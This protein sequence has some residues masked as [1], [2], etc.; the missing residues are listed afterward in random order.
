MRT[1]TLILTCSLLLPLTA[2]ARPIVWWHTSD[3]AVE[4]VPGVRDKMAPEEAMVAEAELDVLRGERA[5]DE[6]KDAR[7]QARHDRRDARMALREA[8]R[9]VRHADRDDNQ[10]M[11]EAIEDRAVAERA[12][13]EAKDFVVLQKA[14]VH[15]AREDKQWANSRLSAAIAQREFGEATLRTLDDD[16]YGTVPRRFTRQ[17]ERVSDE[18]LDDE[19]EYMM[20]HA[21]VREARQDHW[22][23]EGRPMVARLETP[24][25]VQYVAVEVPAQQPVELHR[26]H[27][28]LGEDEV[29]DSYRADLQANAEILRENR[30]VTVRIEGHTDASGPAADNLDLAWDRAEAVAA[31]LRQ[32]GVWDSQIE[33]VAFGEGRPLV[34]T[35]D[36]TTLNRR[37]ELRVLEPDTDAVVEGTVEGRD[38]YEFSDEPMDGMN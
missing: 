34:D 33:T 20:A 8:K 16:P 30:E 22:T 31:S 21:D 15:A 35:D 28:A 7:K 13:A 36:A 37:V 9:D 18:V 5:I 38:G 17:V 19:R 10:G 27:F 6:A 26:L 4:E 23:G 1:P 12:L 14:R 2:D 29:M 25:V 24:A 3:N 32:M 11:R